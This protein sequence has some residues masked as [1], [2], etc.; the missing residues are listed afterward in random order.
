[1]QTQNLRLSPRPHHGLLSFHTHVHT[2]SH[3]CSRP[4]KNKGISRDALK[5]LYPSCSHSGI[6]SSRLWKLCC[7]LATPNLKWT[8]S[9]DQMYPS[10]QSYPVLVILSPSFFNFRKWIKHG[11]TPLHTWIVRNIFIANAK[12]V[13]ASGLRR[14]ADKFLPLVPSMVISERASAIPFG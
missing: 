6:C 7:V 13:N 14:L 9:I 4:Q 8:L 1:M 3:V 10:N 12:H 11:K 5:V 2:G